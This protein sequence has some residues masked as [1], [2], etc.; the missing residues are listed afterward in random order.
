MVFFFSLSFLSIITSQKFS[1][2]DRNTPRNITDI[3]TQQNAAILANN[4][5]GALAHTAEIGSAAYRSNYNMGKGEY[6]RKR[7]TRH[8][9]AT[10][11][12]RGPGPAAYGNLNRT[13]RAAGAS[14]IP[15]YYRKSGYFGRYGT[16]AAGS[17]QE[18]K[19]FDQTHNDPAGDWSAGR[20]GTS[21]NLVPQGDTES[22]R[23]G[24]MIKIHSIQVRG[25]TELATNTSTKSP[26]IRFFLFLDKQCNGAE[27]AVTDVLE[28]AD[29]LAHNKL[30][31]SGRFVTLKTWI[32]CMNQIAAAGNGTAN[33]W[34]ELTRTWQYYK[35]FKVPIKIQFSGA[36]GALTEIK[37]N[38]LMLGWIT[39]KVDALALEY[40]TRI[41]YTD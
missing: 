28:A 31:N 35:S 6:K 25:K 12:R 15:G 1:I 3:L 24:R 23:V 2:F 13:L 22:T 32:I 5:I 14:Y 21:W 11:R 34:G 8:R 29:F 10:T 18:K 17:I 27:P 4:F 7:V 20:I 30:E 38:N 41:R 26:C 36:T 9:Y 19:F 16:S 40:C 37:S 39:D 33:D